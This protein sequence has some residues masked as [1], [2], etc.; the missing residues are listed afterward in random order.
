MAEISPDRDAASTEAK[1]ADELIRA[2][3][4]DQKRVVSRNAL[5]DLEPVPEEIDPREAKRARKILAAAQKGKHPGLR[6]RISSRITGY[7]PRVKHILLA[8]LALVMFFRPWL[9]PGLLFVA[10]WV[11]LVAYLTMG[12]DR[13]V[14]IISNGWDRF[15]KRYPKRAERLRQRADR[16]AL[17]F[18]A[19]LDRLPDSWAEKLALPDLSQPSKPDESLDER[20]DPFDRLR[21]PEVY[22]G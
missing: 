8:A 22:R 9:I 4:S 10:F 16:F 6:D 11:V 19:M 5:P 7:R 2:V 17:K 15:V 3:M 14:E 1:S 21:Q 12:H 20:P 18:D 13:M